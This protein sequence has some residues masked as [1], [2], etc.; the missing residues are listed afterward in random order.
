MPEFQL[1]GAVPSD[2]FA[3]GYIE[4]MFFTNCDCGDE[5]EDLANQLG[6]GRLTLASRAAIARDCE[7]FQRD[8]EA[9]LTEAYALEPGSEAYRYAREQLDPRRAGQL[10]WFARQGH[11]VT[12]S[13]NGDAP[14]LEALQEVSRAMGE[15][16]PEIYR[17]WIHVR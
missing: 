5:R 3:A 4:A 7:R 16:Y 13:D 2:D 6:T 1:N 14:C 15:S 9:L 12:W 10:F 11:G 8:H 17:G